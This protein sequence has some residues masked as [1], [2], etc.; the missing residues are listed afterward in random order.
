MGIAGRWLTVGLALGAPRW[1]EDGSLK[2]FT[3][4][5]T[6]HQTTGE[7]GLGSEQG[8]RELMETGNPPWDNDVGPDSV[9]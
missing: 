3:E 2:E 4:E 1:E 8:R 6:F 5:E 7:V 9:P